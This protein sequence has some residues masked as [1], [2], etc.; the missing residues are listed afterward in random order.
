M[1]K[2]KAR[3]SLFLYISLD[4]QLLFISENIL[5]FVFYCTFYFALLTGWLNFL[6]KSQ[7]YIRHKKGVF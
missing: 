6:G 7:V 5:F 2:L 4:N 1:F 3:P